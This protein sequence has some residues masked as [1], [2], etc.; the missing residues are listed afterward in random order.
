MA[1]GG[2]AHGDPVGFLPGKRERGR[3]GRG[4]GSGQGRRGGG[5]PRL[6]EVQEPPERRVRV[7]AALGVVLHPEAQQGLALHDLHAQVAALRDDVEAGGRLGDTVAVVEARLEGRPGAQAARR[8]RPHGAL[9]GARGRQ[10]GDAPAI[11]QRDHLQ[12]EADAEHRNVTAPSSSPA[13]RSTSRARCA[14]AAS[15]RTS[16][17]SCA[18]SAPRAGV[19]GQRPGQVAL[20]RCPVDEDRVGQARGAGRRVRRRARC[21]RLRPP[22]PPRGR[23][24]RRASLPASPIFLFCVAFTLQGGR[25]RRLSRSCTAVSHNILFCG[26]VPSRAKATSFARLVPVM[27]SRVYGSLTADPDP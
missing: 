8:T 18:V 4:H 2:P 21:R 16:W 5:P 20:V 26:T 3:H 6:A 1:R 13:R 9:L 25:R 19:S 10:A 27:A 22:P 17:C 7:R 12:A 15:R 11:G 23:R 24:L 14:R